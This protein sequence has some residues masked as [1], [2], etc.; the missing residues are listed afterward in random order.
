M[1]SL[2]QAS[3]VYLL[4]CAGQTPSVCAPSVLSLECTF[5][6]GQIIPKADIY[7]LLTVAVEQH[8]TFCM[9]SWLAFVNASQFTVI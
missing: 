2:C 7:Q 4:S 8:Y 9:L 5:S 6:Q 3:Q 1:F